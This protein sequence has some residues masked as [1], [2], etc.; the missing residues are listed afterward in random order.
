MKYE[1]LYTRNLFRLRISS[2]HSQEVAQISPKLINLEQG[3]WFQGVKYVFI[4]C[5]C[6]KYKCIHWHCIGFMYYDIYTTLPCKV[7]KDISFILPIILMYFIIIV[8]TDADY[9][10]YVNIIKTKQYVRFNTAWH[11]TL[12]KPFIH[13]YIILSNYLYKL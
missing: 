8:F 11:Q 12:N 2:K 6:Y 3:N 4:W 7:N 9:N 5:L 1:L 13:N 10:V